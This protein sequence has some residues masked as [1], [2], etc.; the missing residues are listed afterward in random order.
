MPD[1]ESSTEPGPNE[2]YCSS[3]GEVIKEEAKVCPECGVENK[4]NEDSSTSDRRKRELEDIV[5]QNK[6]TVILLSI[7]VTPLGYYWVGKTGLALLNFFTFN[8]LFLGPIIVP[9][10]TNKIM[11][12][13]Q[14]E[15]DSM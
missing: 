2:V 7:F 3:C 15:L 10:H 9:F 5:H 11:N 12:D 6:T 1:D 8:Y 4:A 14:K 13:A